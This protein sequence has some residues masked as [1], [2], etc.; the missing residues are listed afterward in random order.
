[1]FKLR[2]CVHTITFLFNYVTLRYVY[3]AFCYKIVTHFVQLR[4]IQLRKCVHT[5]TFLLNNE[6]FMCKHSLKY[7]TLLI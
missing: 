5:I 6:T 1:M 7:V 4:F 3:F 2:K